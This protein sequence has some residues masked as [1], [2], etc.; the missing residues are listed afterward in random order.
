M[1]ST[2][3]RSVSVERDGDAGDVGGDVPGGGG[4][5]TGGGSGDGGGRGLAWARVAGAM[6]LTEG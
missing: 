6:V 3:F 2:S 1:P 5:C 4:S